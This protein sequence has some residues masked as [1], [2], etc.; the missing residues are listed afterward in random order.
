MLQV[1]G[2]FG[3]ISVI[4]YQTQIHTVQGGHTVPLKQYHQQPALCV[5][6]LCSSLT[7]AHCHWKW[8]GSTHSSIILDIMETTVWLDVALPIAG[9]CLC[10]DMLARYLGGTAIV[11]SSMNYQRLTYVHTWGTVY[12]YHCMWYLYKKYYV[13]ANANHDTQKQTVRTGHNQQH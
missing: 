7:Y 4:W 1:A 11:I 3:S 2:R 13:F 10:T 5:W 6:P 12:V 8:Q 9:G